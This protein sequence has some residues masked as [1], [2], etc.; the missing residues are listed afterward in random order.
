MRERIDRCGRSL[1]WF[2][3]GIA[4]CGVV[5]A[6]TG[7]FLKDFYRPVEASAWQDIHKLHTVSYGL[8]I[9]N[10]HRWTSAAYVGF[11]TATVIVSLTVGVAHRG[12]ARRWLLFTGSL[13]IVG[14]FLPQPSVA[15]AAN[16]PLRNWYAIHI[17]Q[18]SFGLVMIAIL[19]FLSWASWRDDRRAVTRRS[20]ETPDG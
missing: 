11:V 15:M 9:R 20:T 12:P 1:R 5:L 7:E 8:L 2:G 14:Y 4:F 16:D 6:G 17:W 13:I 18:G 19:T 10:L 3:C